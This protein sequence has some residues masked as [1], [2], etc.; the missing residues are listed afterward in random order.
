[1]TASVINV[2]PMAA[3]E[4][5]AAVVDPA[6]HVGVDVEPALRAELVADTD[7]PARRPTAAAV[8]A[9]RALR[10]ED[11]VGAGAGGLPPLGRAARA[12]VAPLR[13]VLPRPGRR[14]AARGVAGVPPARSTPSE[15]RAA[16]ASPRAAARAH[17]TGRRSRRALGRARSRSPATACCPFDRDATG[18]DA[19]VEIAH[20]ALLWGWERLGDW[21]ETHRDGPAPP[22]VTGRRRRRVGSHRAAT[23]TT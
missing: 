18:G 14:P 10:T 20:E 6:R 17:G 12:P 5:E 21:I 15:D 8:H 23:R 16:V 7:E 22:A 4:L 11:G 2:L 19:V 3:D 9:D 13:A 1:M